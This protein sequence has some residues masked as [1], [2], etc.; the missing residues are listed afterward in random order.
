LVSVVRLPVTT[1]TNG[2]QPDLNSPGT[3][4]LPRVPVYSVVSAGQGSVVTIV[5][6]ALYTNTITALSAQNRIALVTQPASR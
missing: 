5:V 6:P 2:A 4:I 1:S 3:P